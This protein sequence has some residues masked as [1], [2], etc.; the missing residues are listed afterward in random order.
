MLLLPM[1]W[2]DFVTLCKFM[3]WLELGSLYNWEHR[4]RLNRRGVTAKL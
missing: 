3:F 2:A 1:V 4:E